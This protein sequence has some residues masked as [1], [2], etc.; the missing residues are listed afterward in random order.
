MSHPAARCAALIFGGAAAV[1]LMNL[2]TDVPVFYWDKRGEP[3]LLLFA[4]LLA[5]IGIVAP[6]FRL[7]ANL[8]RIPPGPGRLFANPFTKP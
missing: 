5:R 6:L 3:S 1:A 2:V 4:I 8:D 7:D